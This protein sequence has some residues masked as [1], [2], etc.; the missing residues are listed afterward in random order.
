[1]KRSTLVLIAIAGLALSI[2]ATQAQELLG[3]KGL[4]IAPSQ[5]L[6]VGAT[7]P[8]MIAAGQS[9]GADVTFATEFS[10]APYCTCAYVAG[11]FDPAT[12]TLI[13]SATTT[14]LDIDVN[15]GGSPPVELQY[16]C[17]GDQ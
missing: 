17:I 10:T 16:I 14:T 9:S 3:N 6:V 12:D 1:V 5:I 15:G 4:Y 7:K 8:Q 11:G 13:C 2:A